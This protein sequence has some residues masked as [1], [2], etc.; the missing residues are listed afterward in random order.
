M[1]NR[2]IQLTDELYDYLLNVSV[3]EPEILRRLRE[4][5]LLMPEADL[6]IAPEQG[7]LMALMLRLMSA[8]RV[9]EIGT[10]TGY[11]SLAMALA[12]PTDGELVT[13]DLSEEWTAIARKYWQEAGVEDRITLCLGPALDT[14]DRLL[15]E[16]RRDSFDFA[17]IDADKENDLVYFERCMKLVRTGGLIVVD[18]VLWSGRVA[19]PKVDDADTASIRVF[20][21]A[22][23]EDERIDLSL[24]P[25]ADG[26]T[27]AR[28][29]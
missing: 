26:L 6:E 14:L 22:L 28:K 8:K 15:A 3:R 4:Q 7:Q 12:L 16:G 27:L 10:F 18:N 11:S 20:N 25:I 23:L 2:T 29:R 21:R 1:S 19:D 24:V 13:C 9:L 17:F 5:T